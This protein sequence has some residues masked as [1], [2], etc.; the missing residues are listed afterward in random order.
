MC[1]SAAL[2]PAAVTATPA[3]TYTASWVGNSL[4]GNS[5]NAMQGAILDAYVSAD[6]TVYTNS[7]WDEA[8][9][10]A[11][12]YKNGGRI[13]NP[14]HTHGWG[15]LGGGAITANS[16]Y[17]YLAGRFDSEAG[18]LNAAYP[19]NH[20][21]PPTGMVWFGVSRRPLTTPGLAAP[22]PGGKGG[23]GDTLDRSFLVVEQTTATL[24]VKLSA[25]API[26]G[27]AATDSKLFVS[28]ALGN[29]I[30]VFDANTMALITTFAFS[31]PG[32]IVADHEGTLWIAQTNTG[33]IYHI[34]DNGIPYSSYSSYSSRITDAG[35]PAALAFSPAGELIVGDGSVRQQIRIYNISR[36]APQLVRTFGDLNG[37]YSGNPGEIEDTKLIQPTGVGMDSSANLYVTGTLAG[38]E[39]R[40]FSASGLLL[41]NLRGLEYVDSAIADPTSDG[42]DVY[43][44]KE[45]FSMNYNRAPGSE[46]KWKALTVNPYR[47]PNDLRVT[48]PNGQSI[49]NSSGPPSLLGTKRGRWEAAPME[50]ECLREVVEGIAILQREPSPPRAI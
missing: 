4:P 30:A 44:K 46:W 35:N 29:R 43:T 32:K 12:I 22:F 19:G 3:L 26:T 2:L 38:A 48:S 20:S 36:T 1:V 41:W 11:A 25:L 28:D 42:S 50:L 47:Y 40:A 8:G 39:I 17:L 45:H 34:H 6:G 24:S 15:A 16:H 13:T 23:D 49:R 27:L 21:W 10:E 9:A 37:V 14:G 31:N 33:F 5:A 7:V 18:L